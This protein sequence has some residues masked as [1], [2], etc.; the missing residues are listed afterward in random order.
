M[1]RLENTKVPEVTFKTRVR[2][3]AVGGDNPFRWQDV[4]SNEL[5]AGKKV[6]LF[7]LPG[8]FT[9]TCSST[10]APGYDKMA[11]E[12]KAL[13]VDQ[14]ICLSVNDAFVMYQWA[15]NLGTENIFMLPDG[16]LDFT[17]AIGM[18][19]KKENLGFGERSWRYSML[20][21]DGTI[22]K[23]FEEDGFGDNVEGDPFMVSDAETM[24][25]YLKS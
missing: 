19:V 14:I 8:A 1:H 12:F 6:I 24:L 25:K 9:P 15:K 10:H 18:N 7:G 4:T 11:S 5:F 2:D 20:I 17:R 22:T 13:G 23:V 16:N 21:E 3:E